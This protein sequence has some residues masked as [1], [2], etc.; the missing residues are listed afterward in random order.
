MALSSFESAPPL[1]KRGIW[2]VWTKDRQWRAN[3][4]LLARLVGEPVV[5]GFSHGMFAD[6]ARDISDPRIASFEDYAC[7]IAGAANVV[8]NRLHVA[9]PAAAL[10]KQVYL[11]E[12]GYHKLS[13]V[14]QRSLLLVPNIRL[15]PLR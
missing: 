13:G 4:D 6:E 14:Y 9:L 3:M 10:G 2:K 11:V 8:T 5:D 12:S 15:V 7:A 1:V